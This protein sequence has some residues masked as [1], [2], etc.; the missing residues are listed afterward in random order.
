[1]FTNEVWPLNSFRV[2][3]DLRPWILDMEMCEGESCKCVRGV[4]M[5]V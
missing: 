4:R 5:D 3:P 1:M 2:F